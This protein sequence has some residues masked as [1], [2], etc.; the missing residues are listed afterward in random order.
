MLVSTRR[1]FVFTGAPDAIAILGITPPL[2]ALITAVSSMAAVTEHVKEGTREQEQEW[3]RAEQVRAVLREQEEAGDRSESRE[4]PPG[5]GSSAGV[6][7]REP[8]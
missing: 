5:S 4:R 1:P 6:G 7:H 8:L 2:F 3:Q